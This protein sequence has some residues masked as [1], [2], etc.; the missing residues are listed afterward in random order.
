MVIGRSHPRDPSVP[1]IDLWGLGIDE[2]R[3]ASR[4]HCRVFA[5]GDKYYLEDLG[6]MNGTFL[7]DRQ[8]QP[9]IKQPLKV[10]D[11]IMAGR[12]AL[13]FSKNEA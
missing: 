8:L 11:R 4:R 3:T 10:G 12:V 5:E 7:N 9:N 13:T 6:S 2:A 1:D